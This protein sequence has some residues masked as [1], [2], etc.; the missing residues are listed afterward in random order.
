MKWMRLIFATL[1]VVASVPVWP[2][3]RAHDEPALPGSKLIRGGSLAIEAFD[4]GSYALRSTTIP[5]DVLRSDVEVDTAAG[6]LKSSLYPRHSSSVAPFSDAL[7][8]GQLLTVTYAG[9]PGAP[10][11][12]CELRVYENQPW[13]DIRVTVNNSTGGSIEVHALR[14]LNSNAGAVLNLNGPAWEDRVLSD[15]FTEDSVKLMDLGEPENG[16]HRAFGSQLIYNRQ[17]GQSLFLGALSAGRLL[18]VLGVAGPEQRVPAWKHRSIPPA[19]GGWRKH[20]LGAADVL[21]RVRLS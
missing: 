13:G 10:D 5:G 12:V 19:S 9:L 21:N 4:D 15:S 14:V 8:S 6:T 1:L 18:T 2:A 7:G 11:L 17:S 20:R 16:A 3:G